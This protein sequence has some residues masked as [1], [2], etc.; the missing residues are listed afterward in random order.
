MYKAEIPGSGR[1]CIE[2]ENELGHM[3]PE[4]RLFK[5]NGSIKGQMFFSN[6]P[7]PKYK[8]FRQ[9]C[10]DCLF[11]K[12]GS[13]DAVSPNTIGPSFDYVMNIDTKED[14]KKRAT[15]ELSLIQK[16]GEVE[17]LARWS[18]YKRVQAET[19]TYEYKRM[20]YGWTK[21]EFDAYN[22]SRASTESNYILR[23]GVEEGKK[24]W[25][26]YRQLQKHAGCSKEW[27]IEK[28][29][30][31]KG[32]KVYD[33]VCKSKSITLDKFI[34]KYGD[35][36][37]ESRFRSWMDSI[38]K[39]KSASDFAN[40]FIRDMVAQLGYRLEEMYCSESPKGEMWLYSKRNKKSYCYDFAWNFKIIEVHG[41]YWHMN[42]TI[43]P[44]TFYHTLQGLTA[45]D[46][47]HKDRLK[48]ECAREC[49]NQVLEVWESDIRSNRDDVLSRC[50]EFMNATSD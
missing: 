8:V 34:S 49:G 26:E 15:T 11:V 35:G 4:L 17:G 20:K 46:I 14:R 21:E 41:D 36:E 2:C 24:K 12:T 38:C 1:Y 39:Q 22:S 10:F 18:E 13:F 47:W 19:N 5:K 9:R 43:Y 50:V 40:D 28:H 42:P 27:F 25:E 3:N 7:H 33:E 37:G 23:H 16:Y 29:G 31:S 6:K 32:V 30:P 45:K 44:E 48:M